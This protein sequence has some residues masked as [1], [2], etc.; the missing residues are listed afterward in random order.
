MLRGGTDRPKLVSF[1]DK[2]AATM[3]RTALRCAIETL[4]KNSVNII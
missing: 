3:P 1:P 2:Y 4:D